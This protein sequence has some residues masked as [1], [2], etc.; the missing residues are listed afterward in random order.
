MENKKENKGVKMVALPSAII[1][2]EVKNTSLPCVSELRSTIGFEKFLHNVYINKQTGGK[3]LSVQSYLGNLM[4]F[5]G[6]SKTIP[7][8]LHRMNYVQLQQLITKFRDL[9][10]THIKRTSLNN[11]LSTCEAYVEYYRFTKGRY[12]PLRS[13]A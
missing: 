6:L 2:V 1:S 13:A 5:L 7:E 3:F 10:P 8:N 11:L 9:P 12:N 4:M